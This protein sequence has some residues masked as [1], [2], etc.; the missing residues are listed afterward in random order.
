[1][2]LAKN[3]K[4]K[5]WN[6]NFFLFEILKYDLTHITNAKRIKWKLK[7]LNANLKYM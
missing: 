4:E 6:K 1:M 2:Q 5:K 7:K 3:W